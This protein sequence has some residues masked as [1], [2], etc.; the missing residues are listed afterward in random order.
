M[1]NYNM[2]INGQD[3]NAKILEFNANHAKVNVNG[4]D[5]DIE[6]LNDNQEVKNNYIQT[7]KPLPVVP[8]IK[9]S[10]K[11]GF[12][13]VKAPIPGVVVSVLKNE[14]DKVKTG[15]LLLTLEA[16]KMESEILSPVDGTI[17]KI[18]V[19][20]KSPVQEGDLMVKI[21]TEN[22][23]QTISNPKPVNTS[24]TS[25][26]APSIQTANV[27]SKQPVKAPLPG[28]ILDIKV[29]VGQQVQADQP[30][31]VLEAMKMESEI[32]TNSAGTVKSINVSKGQSVQ[33]GQILIEI[34]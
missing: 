6:F 28:T 19:K 7:D 11:Q 17:E 12:N 21:A 13:E 29:N 18:F 27:S 8:Q 15:D 22:T 1:K 26:P 32:F 16:M 2:K 10:S 20:D 23:P 34:S 14:G 31:I 5:F 30:V 24:N 33:E 9:S 25:K 3:Y 4:V